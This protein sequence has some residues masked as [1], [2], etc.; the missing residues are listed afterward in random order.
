MI[1]KNTI[2]V[3]YKN[4]PY[5]KNYWSEIESILNKRW[6]KLIDLNL[7]LIEFFNKMLKIDTQTLRSSELKI[8][9]MATQRLFD[10]CKKVNATV[11]RSGI[12]GN[13]YL[14]ESIFKDGKISIVYENF[15]HPTYDQ[16]GKPF[17][18]NLAI[19]DLLFHEGENAVKI[20]AEC[21]N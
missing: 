15:Q 7:A 14:D 20:L 12:M 21:T 11:Y 17:I 19:I 13:E 1:I 18:P 6:E 16:L 10:I 9:T 3:N 2:E 4:A 5:F 8:E